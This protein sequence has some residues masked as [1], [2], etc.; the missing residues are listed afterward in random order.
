MKKRQSPIKHRVRTY[1]RKGNLIESYIR[2]S[3]T[4]KPRKKLYSKVDEKQ[5]LAKIVLK[6][7]KDLVKNEYL[8]LPNGPAKDGTDWREGMSMASS[9]S[10]VQARIEELKKRGWDGGKVLAEIKGQEEDKDKGFRIIS[11]WGKQPPESKIKGFQYPVNRQV[12]AEELKKHPRKKTKLVWMSPETYLKQMPSPDIRYTN[13]DD[14]PS[15]EGY[16]KELVTKYQRDIFKSVNT[17]NIKLPPLRLFRGK[18][19]NEGRQ[20]DRHRA[21]GAYLATVKKVPVII[22]EYVGVED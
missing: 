10:G 17:K 19:K 18:Y 20:H 21:K 3:G 11:S 4:R 6:K 8:I 5:Q 12:I 13:A 9:W 15:Y 1:A 22:I 7:P 2:G 14:C 16:N